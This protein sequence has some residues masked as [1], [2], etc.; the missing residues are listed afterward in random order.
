M[1]FDRIDGGRKLRVVADKRR[2]K[3]MLV[4]VSFNTPTAKRWQL[5]AAALLYRLLIKP[6][7]SS[8]VIV[9][10]AAQRRWVNVCTALG[11]APLA[12]A[13]TTHSLQDCMLF[14]GDA[15]FIKTETGRDGDRVYRLEF[16]N[17]RRMFFWMQEPKPEVDDDNVKKLN[18][19]I[20]NP[21]APGADPSPAAGAAGTAGLPNG[22]PPELMQALMGGAGGQGGGNAEASAQAL[23]ALLGGGGGGGG[24]GGLSEDD[25]MAR[26]IAL[27]MQEAAGGDEEGTTA[28]DTA[29]GDN[30][31]TAG[32][33]A[34]ATTPAP[35]G[36]GIS[37]FDIDSFMADAMNMVGGGSGA[38]G[39]ASPAPAQSQ[40]V[41]LSLLVDSGTVDELMGD[42]VTVQLLLPH[43][44]EGHRSPSDLRS[45]LLSPQFQQALGSLTGALQT[46]NF[47]TV[48]ANF[49]LD[50][51]D[52][53]EAVV[54]GDGVGAFVAALQAA[55][56][57]KRAQ[58][59]GD[60]NSK[61]E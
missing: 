55:A 34:A 46:E 36:D 58:Q 50:P 1:H 28:A 37:Q 57:R 18:E 5:P 52:G 17:G 9:T 31:D 24:G 16:S 49:N 47:N 54:R 53:Q 33:P 29:Q 41:P 20:D 44:P 10:M 3:V 4:R 8:G 35:A 21:P 45:T 30:A 23:Q 51:A 38:A 25:E 13:D 22:I 27:S 7:T 15:K 19:S 56:E 2:G 43:L 6:S 32:T 40:P 60:S 59:E 26:A 14:P 42:D 61:D 48:F 12:R 39:A 11:T